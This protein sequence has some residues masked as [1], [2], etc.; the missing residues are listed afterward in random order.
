MITLNGEKIQIKENTSLTELLNEKEFRIALIAVEY[1]GKIP[2]KNE[3]DSIILKD[4][5]I[6]EV[7]SFMGGGSI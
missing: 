4:G 6:I 5:D 3:F 7:V 1:N 2:P